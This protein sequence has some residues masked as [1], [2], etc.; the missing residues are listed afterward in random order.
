MTSRRACRARALACALAL[1]A[2]VPAASAASPA[3]A[4][5]VS[6]PTR[7]VAGKSA[8]QGFTQNQSSI[9]WCGTNVVVG[10]ADTGSLYET[11]GGAAASALGVARSTNGGA[12]YEDLGFLPPGSTA[13][14]TLGG[15]P[16]VACADADTFY[17]ASI[18]TSPSSWGVAVSKSMDG[19]ATWA[20]PTPVLEV[21]AAT[22]TVDQQ[23]IAVDPTDGFV[24]VVYTVHDRSGVPCADMFGAETL[25]RI[26]MVTST[27]GGT[28][29]GGAVDLDDMCDFGDKG[30]QIAHPQI[31]VDGTGRTY[32]VWTRNDGVRP[33]EIRFTRFPDVARHV[34]DVAPVGLLEETLQGHVEAPVTPSIA[35]DR[36]RRPGLDGTMYVAWSDGRRNTVDDVAG[37]AYSYADV[38]V[39][40]S[41]DGGAT[42]SRVPARVNANPE[43]LPGGLGT[44]QF[45]PKIAVDKTGAVGV[46]WYDRRSDPANLLIDRYC[47]KSAN[48]GQTWSNLRK[49]TRSFP[50]LA[51]QEFGAFV[52]P[53]GSD[54][55]VAS[56]FTR[57]FPGFR[58]TYTD[59]TLG[60]ADVKALAF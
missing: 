14:A 19:G 17:Y 49:T 33:A 15:S 24:S 58:G 51:G 8:I 50:P 60:N 35:I 54:D 40:R 29:W 20:A 26:G 36:S 38:F 42:W 52:A 48:G 41:T 30:A 4:G 31:A 23:A 5:R 59:T 27:D 3:A 9:A 25:T 2:S 37:G 10:F 1:A 28:S 34:T 11:L 46:C 18:S 39:T 47:G 7:D 45:A 21:P 55:G 22:A 44:D 57:V 53:H 43:P 12:T 56:D 32:V 6:D 13:G 16:A